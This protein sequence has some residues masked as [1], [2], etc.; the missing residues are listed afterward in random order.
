LY[1]FDFSNAFEGTG[2]V[3]PGKGMSIA[4]SGSEINSELA[5]VNQSA[6]IACPC[7]K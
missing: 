7:V 1:G 6:L 4:V 2:R 3:A 5:Y